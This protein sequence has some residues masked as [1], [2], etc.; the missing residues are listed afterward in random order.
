[1][2]YLC[3]HFTMFVSHSHTNR[4]FLLL[5][6]LLSAVMARADNQLDTLKIEADTI[7]LREL[8]VTGALHPVVQR[9]DTLI[10][11]V[12]SFPIPEGSRLRELLRKPLHSS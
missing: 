10:Y 5:L 6:M 3:T 9:G 12:A 2:S 11:D 4:L 8:T 1:M 7:T